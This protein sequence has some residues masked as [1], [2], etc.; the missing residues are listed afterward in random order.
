MAQAN[1]IQ[2]GM[3]RFETAVKSVEKDFRRLQKRAD[4]RRKELER[5]ADRQLKRIRTELRKNPVMKRAGSAVEAAESFRDDT[6][7]AVGEQV[8]T[9][10]GSLRIASQG[11]VS[12]LERKVGALNRKVRQL[13][14]LHEEE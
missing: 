5:R 7:K 1:I 14:R 9:L 13:E 2:D 3:D 11:E 8:D 4:K 6:V 12:K 10:L